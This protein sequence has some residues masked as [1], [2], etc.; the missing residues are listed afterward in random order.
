[1]IFFF[2]LDISLAVICPVFAKTDKWPSPL[3]KEP[4]KHL[5]EGF[6]FVKLLN[7]RTLFSFVLMVI[8]TVFG[9]IVVI[10]RI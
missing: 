1:M 5:G 8:G 10:E 2:V 3:D 6:T 7:S 4:S 9:I